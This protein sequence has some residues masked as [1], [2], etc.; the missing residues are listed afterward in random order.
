MSVIDQ[1][2]TYLPIVSFT[3]VLFYYGINIRDANR[4]RQA[5]LYMQL[6]SSFR[7]QEVLGELNKVLY[8][9]Q[10]K[11]FEDFQSRYS[12]E[13]NL[14]MS[15]GIQSILLFFEILGGLLKQGFLDI[16]VIDSQVG[17]A[18]IPFWEKIGP[19]IM[20]ERELRKQ[21]TLWNDN[22]YLYEQLT[23]A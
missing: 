3:I 9:H 1:I 17:M 18:F 22:E 15:I 21:P 19:I 8:L 10:W 11:D 13:A 4:S 16:K 2:T 7:S 23:G 12:P 20:A 5:S 14:D 6:Y